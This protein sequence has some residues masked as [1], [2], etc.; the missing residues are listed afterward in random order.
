MTARADILLLLCCTL[1]GATGARAQAP[2]ASGSAANAPPTAEPDTGEPGEDSSPKDQQAESGR[3]AQ[4]LAQGNTALA[5][6][7]GCGGDDAP[8]YAGS[9]VS[10]S[11]T[12]AP[13]YATLPD[14]DNP[15]YALSLYVAPRLTLSD[16]WGLVADITF[17]YEATQPDDTTYRNYLW[18]TD[19]RLTA[20]GLLFKLGDFIFTGGPR[21]IAPTSQAS[22]AA[23]MYAG[24]GAVA[25]VVRQFDLLAG[26]ALTVGGS[27]VHTW[28]G[29][30]TREVR[31]GKAPRCTSLSGESIAC[32]AGDARI[33]QDA[34]RAVGSATLNFTPEWNLQ[35]S[36]IHGFSLVKPFDD[37]VASQVTIDDPVTGSFTVDDVDENPLEDTRWRRIGIFSLAL[38]YQPLSWLIASIQGSTSVCYDAPAGGQSATG[39]CSGGN[40]HSDFWLRNP[41]ANK[42]SNLSLS[43]TVPIDAFVAVV[44]SPGGGEKRAVRRTSGKAK[45]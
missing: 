26:F 44:T 35:A 3:C 33:A 37:D 39:G 4:L 1:L 10:F 45:L 16:D 13:A 23:N 5:Q 41:I 29:N 31:D 19:T 32:S 38:S 30:L 2:A 17:A 6:A 28:S 36:Y 21:L 12:M 8:I 42:F 43:L 15:L 25:N 14:D 34:F 18:R 7:E 22:I 9:I 40:R 27:Y 11:Q 20:T 24:T